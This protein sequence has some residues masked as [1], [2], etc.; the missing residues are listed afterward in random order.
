MSGKN[1]VGK[2]NGNNNLP[3][4]VRWVS[5]SIII[6]GLI[7]IASCSTFATQE[8]PEPITLNGLSFDPVEQAPDFELVD[9]HLRPF[10]LSD[11]QGKL[12]LLYFGFTHCPDECPLTMN[13]WKQVA[14]RLGPNAEQVSFVMISVD[15]ERDS[16][17]VLGDYLANFNTDFFGLSGPVES[18]EDIAFDYNAF[19]KRLRLTE[20]EAMSAHTQGNESSGVHIH[21]DGSVH[22][23]DEE[24]YLVAH[25][26]LTYVI[27]QS[28]QL[29]LAFPLETPPDKIV[30]DLEYLLDL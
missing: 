2:F 4:I 30:S 18:I 19:F 20:E 9:Q 13:I 22:V 5:A 17:E 3:F 11:H 14:E 21:S 15:P 26:T 16:P 6:I 23:H 8:T 12:V 29:V 24:I 28:G 7:L 1:D 25:T 10:Q 27:D